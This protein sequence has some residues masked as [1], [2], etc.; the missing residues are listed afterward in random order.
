MAEAAKLREAGVRIEQIVVDGIGKAM[1][2]LDGKCTI[3][4]FNLL[5]I[6]LVGRAVMGV[7]KELFPKGEPGMPIRG[8]IIIGYPAGETGKRTGSRARTWAH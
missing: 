8:T 7:I 6:M 3:D 5:E 1:D 2:Q 4:Q